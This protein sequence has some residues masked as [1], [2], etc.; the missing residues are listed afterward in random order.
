MTG[1]P[2]GGATHQGHSDSSCWSRGQAW[3]IHGFAQAAINTGDS[4]FLSLA[5]RL[6]DYAIPRLP[7]DAVPEWDYD[8][9]ADA[10]RLRDS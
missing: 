2:I 1:Q 6:A 3:A 10:V 4:S 8:L 5:R 7:A 9:P